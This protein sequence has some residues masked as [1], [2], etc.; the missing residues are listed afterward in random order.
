MAKLSR[1]NV[2][3]TELDAMEWG[4]WE[5]NSRETEAKKLGLVEGEAKGRAEGKEETIKELILS[6]LDNNASLEFISK[7]TNKSINEI[8]KIINQ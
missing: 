4:E 1:N 6:M 3:M 5:I 7:V 2:F 8:K